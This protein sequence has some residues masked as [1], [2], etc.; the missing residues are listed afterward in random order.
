MDVDV[1]LLLPSWQAMARIRRAVL[2]E[3]AAGSSWQAAAA[4]AE[5]AA[6]KLLHACLR[7]V[8]VR[9]LATL[10]KRTGCA[11]K[12][13]GCASRRGLHVLRSRVS[14][15]SKRCPLAALRS[16][17]LVRG[18]LQSAPRGT[19]FMHCRVVSAGCTGL[20]G[21]LWPRQE[22]PGEQAAGSQAA[23]E[24][25]RCAKCQSAACMQVS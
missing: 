20:R 23:N 5:A 2:V 22:Q 21:W 6:R 14:T 12:R 16:T 19:M 17:I 11:C 8:V 7:R 15:A 3:P 9:Q 25:K 1:T 24:L 18:A 10:V 4:P 13:L